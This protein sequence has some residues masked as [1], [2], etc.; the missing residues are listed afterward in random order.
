MDYQRQTGIFDPQKFMWPVTMIGAGGIGSAVLPV[1]AK[2]GITEFS[3][4]DNDR[5]EPCNIPNQ[6]MYREDDIRKN[7]VD[8][9]VEILKSYNS[10]LRVSVEPRR[11]DPSVAL[12]GIVVSGVDSMASRSAIWEGVKDN[13]AVPLYM[14]GRLGGEKLEL[15]TIHPATLEDIEF[16]EQYLFPDSEGVDRPCDE[17]AIIGSAVV[18]AGFIQNNLV[19]WSRGELYYGRI[20][21]NLKTMVLLYEYPVDR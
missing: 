12:D 2:L 15:F 19:R 16:Y 4:W 6:L 13:I 9:A 17:H 5:I 20:I 7:K 18:L 11:F 14:D 10:K 1:L 8:A 3:L 21:L